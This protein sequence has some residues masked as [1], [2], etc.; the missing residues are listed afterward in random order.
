MPPSGLFTSSITESIIRSRIRAKDTPSTLEHLGQKFGK[1]LECTDM[2]IYLLGQVCIAADSQLVDERQFPGKQGRLVFAYL[3][4]ERLRPV[5]RDEL[6]EVVWPGT[7]PATWEV[8]LSA[9]ISK[10]RHLLQR[11]GLPRNT[12]Q[13]A[14]HSG[15]YQIH[16]TPHTWVDREA[17]ARAVDEAE[18]AMRT[19]V[20][21]GNQSA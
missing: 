11:L 21:G 12:V 9:L 7:L 4:C 20:L 15:C 14:A 10:L 13:I 5:T 3:V 18:G 2:R 1:P 17:A 6:A 8:S 16:L 19:G